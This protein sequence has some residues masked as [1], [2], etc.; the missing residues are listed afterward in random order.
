MFID[1]A[2][3][4]ARAGKGGDGA[5]SFRREKYVPAGGPDGG[6]GGRGGHIWL[7][8]DP[9]LTTL[10][11]YRYKT[12]YA[13]PN[14]GRGGGRLCAGRGG[15]DMTLRLPP[16]TLVYDDE[17]ERL[18]ADLSDETPFLLCKGGR[19]G[20]GNK[21]FAGARRQAPN[22]AKSGL[23]GEELRVRLEVKMIADVGLA[24]FPNAGKSTLLSAI[25][26]ARP[27]IAGYPFTTL[28]PHLGVVYTGDDTSFLCADI[29]GLIEG[30]ADGAG[31]G[32]EFLRHIE[33]C[34][35]LLHVVDAAGTEGRDPRADIDAIDA[36]LKAHSPEL[37]ERPQIVAA[38]KRDAVSDETVFQRLQEHV[39]PREMFVIS[40]AT[41]EGVD[42]LV[43][44][45]AEKLA[46]LPPVRVF[47]PDPAPEEL[48]VP[49]A[50]TDFSK[51]DGV[52]VLSGDWLRRMIRDV[53]FDDLESLAWFERRLKAGGVYDRLETLGAAEG[54][55]V[56]IYGL[57]F[58]YRR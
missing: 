11:D 53:N 26:A 2:V 15:E 40:A 39:G 17:S 58:E 44:A 51:E 23:E 9:R 50:V 38:N 19:G 28:T 20:W 31:L 14:G 48:P 30:A 27:K 35:L 36:E 54:D 37:A 18:L 34:R 3:I 6:D 56:E 33:R 57:T 46:E 43:R 42:A 21:R 13:A 10:S 29:P 32:H 4:T 22:F 49:E 41:G 47:E 16:G 45:C 52:W 12:K 24:G 55:T 1:T 5:V 7:Q 8:A 25:S